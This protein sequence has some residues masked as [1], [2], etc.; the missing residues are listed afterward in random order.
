MRPGMMG[1]ERQKQ[2]MRQ[3]ANNGYPVAEEEDDWFDKAKR[4]NNRYP[5]RGN[6]LGPP[7]QPRNQPNGGGRVNIQIRGMAGAGGS[8]QGPA[9]T[10]HAERMSDSRRNGTSDRRYP[11][12]DR[13]NPA[14]S[15]YSSGQG[16]G[17]VAEWESDYRQSDQHFRQAPLAP[18]YRQGNA[19]GRGG[20]G[21]QYGGG[22]GYANGGQRGGHGGQRQYYG[23]Y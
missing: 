3:Q 21:G 6:R 13:D 23:G 19:S 22:R 16:G 15:F 1:R 9:P 8:G 11:P 7:T 10:M 20:R 18:D 5:G 17:S 4:G 2:V 12:N 14:H